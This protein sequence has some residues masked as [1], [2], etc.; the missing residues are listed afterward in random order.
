MPDTASP[1]RSVQR[2]ALLMVVLSSFAMPL[3]LSSVTVALPAIAQ[4]LSMDALLLSW[5]P[6]VFLT[7][8]AATVLAFGRLADMYGRKRI[9]TLGTIGSI[10]SSLLTA[11]APNGE[12]LIALRV[13]Q[14]L[15][16][17]M[18][19][20]TQVA[21]LSSVF[22]PQERGKAIGIMASGVYFGLTCGPLVGG[23]LIEHFGWRAAFVSHVPLALIVLLVGIPRV[24]GEWAAAQRGRFDVGGAALYAGAI[25]A[26][27]G[28]AS[29]LPSL[30]G[31]ALLGAGA[32]GMGAFFHHQ[33]G[34]DHPLFDVSLFYTNRAFTLSSLASLLMY[35]ATFSILVLLSLYL[36]YLKNLPP[37]K[38]GLV[39]FVQPLMTALVSPLAGRLSDRIEPRIIASFGMGLTAIGLYLLSSLDAATPLAVVIA[40]LVVA[41]LGFSLFASPNA[42]AIMS[43]IGKGQYG[44]ASGAVATMRVL[45]QLCSM[46]LVAMCFALTIGAVEI[47]PANYP[48][49]ARGI[50]LSFTL[51]AAL[52]LPGM[53]CSLA[54]GRLR[55][56]GA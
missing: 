53:W 29:A 1:E 14:G 13:L 39:M 31:F 37:T 38:A 42:N 20:A 7:S 15:S 40:Y 43:F 24:P 8:S 30:W 25:V 6:L 3:M 12:I 44:S 5:V 11:A 23:W 47:T 10:V 41:G 9:F 27:M 46:G 49:L 33:H 52:C 18:L 51:A 17:A 55:E 28:G 32:A 36:Q 56:Q 19:Y 21:I 2:A 22:P 16:A 50:E 54:R 45:G 4:R 26:L 34:R 35:T 48:A